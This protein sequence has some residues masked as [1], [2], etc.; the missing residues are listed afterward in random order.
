[1]ADQAAAASAIV[2]EVVEAGLEESTPV[3]FHAKMRG[4]SC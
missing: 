2:D 1:V 3:T 4:S